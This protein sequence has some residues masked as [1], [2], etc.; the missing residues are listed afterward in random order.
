MSKNGLMTNKE[1]NEDYMDNIKEQ[2][3][4]D[5]P[6]CELTKRELHKMA[7]YGYYYNDIYHEDEPFDPLEEFYDDLQYN[8]ECQQAEEECKA[9]EENFTAKDSLEGKEYV[10]V[11]VKKVLTKKKVESFTPY[12]EIKPKKK[13]Y[14]SGEPIK[15]IRL[16]KDGDGGSYRA[17]PRHNKKLK[18]RKLALSAINAIYYEKE[19]M[20]EVDEYELVKED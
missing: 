12:V 10:V 9:P 7:F 19:K 8:H 3:A 14:W 1:A 2:V 17:L 16:N 4:H 20:L 18:R 11:K 13:I 6:D 5:Y 15:K